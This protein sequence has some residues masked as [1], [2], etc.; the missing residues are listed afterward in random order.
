MSNVEGLLSAD[1]RLHKRRDHADEIWAVFV[2]TVVKKR[3]VR[4]R[5]PDTVQ[6]GPANPALP[7]TIDD[8]QCARHCRREKRR[9]PMNE[10]FTRTVSDWI[11]ML[12][13][14]TGE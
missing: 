1:I 14:A 8:M 2:E 12:P 6:S 13:Q 11:S 4:I 5:W 7:T 9:G 3:I 10:R